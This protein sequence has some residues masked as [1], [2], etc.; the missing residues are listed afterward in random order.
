[1]KVKCKHLILFFLVVFIM[2]VSVYAYPFRTLKSNIPKYNINREEP[3]I[4]IQYYPRESCP[5]I[6]PMYV[7][8]NTWFA[9]V[10]SSA[11]GYGMVSSVTRPIDVNINGKWLLVYRQ[12]VDVGATHGQIGAAYSINGEDWQIQYNINPPWGETHGTGSYP[13]A[14]ATSDYPYAFWI[15]NGNQWLG[16]G[17]RPSYSYD[18]FGWDGQSW[19]LPMDV[20]PFFSADKDM[21]IGSVAHGFDA[22][23]GNY[24]IS[25]V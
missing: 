18:E 10:D 5:V 2:V 16:S 22:T 20:D 25:A 13:S 23:S 14:I 3:S 11:N 9:L 19:L 15:N 24:Q 7:D 1:M 17:G 8:D 12:F 6:Y 4:K 21:K